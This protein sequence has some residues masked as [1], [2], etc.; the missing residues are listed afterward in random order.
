MSIEN[1]SENQ[2]SSKPLKILIV[3]DDP[4]NL[5]TLSMLLTSISPSVVLMKALNGLEATRVA[6]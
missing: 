5:L 3:D 6:S 4:F 2:T 1:E